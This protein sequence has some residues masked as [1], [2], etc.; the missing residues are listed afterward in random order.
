MLIW[1]QSWEEN[2]KTILQKIFLRWS[3]MQVFRKTMENNWSKKKLF[4]IKGKL[5]NK[6]CFSGNL[7]AIK[8]KKKKH[9]NIQIFYLGLSIL[10]ISKIVMYEFEYD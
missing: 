7:L 4:S 10:E 3:A 5:S 9:A 8:I 2:Q 1:T 6:L